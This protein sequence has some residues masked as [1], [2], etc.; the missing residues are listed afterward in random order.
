[1]NFINFCVLCAIAKLHQV[2]RFEWFT[3]KIGLSYYLG[4]DFANSF[5]SKVCDQTLKS[6]MKEF[7]PLKEMVFDNGMYK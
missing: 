7:D 1:M 5:L 6:L 2:N 4:R 3:L